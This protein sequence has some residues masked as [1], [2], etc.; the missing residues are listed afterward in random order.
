MRSYHGIAVSEGIAIAKALVFREEALAVPRYEIPP[1]DVAS[2]YQRLLQAVGRASADLVKLRDDPGRSTRD[3]AILDAHLLML[4][5]PDFL[6]RM[7]RDLGEELTNV[8]WLL[9][10]YSDELTDRIRASE[11]E[12][13]RER[14]ADVHD[15][16]QRVISHLL[17][18][19]RISLED[20]DGEVV[21]VGHYLLPSDAVM[22]DPHRVHGLA[23][24]LGGKTSHTAII[25]RSFGIPAVL[26]LREASRAVSNGDTVIVDGRAGIVVVEPDAET[27]ER[28]KGIRSIWLKREADLDDLSS[29]PAGTIDGRRVRVDANIEV[30]GEVDAVLQHGAEGIGLFRSEFLYLSS[31][32]EPTEGEQAAVYSDVLRRMDG[33]PVTI[34]TFDLGGEKS[35]PGLTMRQEENPILGWRAIRYCLANPRLF[36][37]Q[38]RALLRASV[39]GD[40]RIMIPMVSGTE[41]LERAREMIEEARGELAAEGVKMAAT[42]PLGIMI[43]IPSAAL[44]SDV[45]A[46]KVDFFSIGTNDLMQYT[47]AMDRSNERVAYLYEPFHLG[48][49]R[50][51][52]MIIENAHAA[53]IPVGLCGE[54]AADPGAALVLLGMGI[55]ELSMSPFSIAAVK[56]VIRGV[57]SVEVASLVERVTAAES[58][59]EA[60]KEVNR[61]LEAK[62]GV[63]CA[64]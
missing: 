21:L 19:E 31:K 17:H 23:L 8:E 55:D 45:L 22:L 2:Q 53:G 5:D 14:A 39:H 50:L 57:T 29:L 30:P 4:E 37:A 26:G 27:L 18:R 7:R 34:R 3:R 20:I 38:L 46:R 40:L 42:V 10:R 32:G 13:M 61:M 12:Y 51:L 48:V 56:R 28:Y 47:L 44:T 15:V 25:A 43:E 16:T 9:V 63:D 6:E 60:E 24:D 41:E 11:D 35:V 54:L 59:R 1:G 62:F 64:G 33:R 52:K 49:L 36:K 58:P